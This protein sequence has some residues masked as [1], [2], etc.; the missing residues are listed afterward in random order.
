MNLIIT[1]FLVLAHDPHPRL[2]VPLHLYHSHRPDHPRCST[3]Q[4]SK[5]LYTLNNLH[6]SHSDEFL[7]LLILFAHLSNGR[8]L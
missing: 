6:Q 3:E 4:P 5:C 1:L 2:V 8:T 7:V